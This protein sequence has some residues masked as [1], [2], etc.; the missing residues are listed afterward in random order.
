[1]RL[2]SRP[3]NLL[4]LDEPTNDLDMETLDLLQELIEGF[5]GTVI[6]VSHDRDFLDRT[7]TSTIAPEGDGRWIEYAGGFSDMMAQ[8]KGEALRR[9]EKSAGSAPRGEGAGREAAQTAAR[10][11]ARKLSYKQKYA[12][13]TLP[14]RIEELNGKIALLEE[15]LADTTLYAR[16]PDAFSRFTKELDEKRAERDRLEEEWLELEILREEIEAGQA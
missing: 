12:P 13:D 6:L 11:G 10:Q 7:V 8:R 5:P 1:A 4:V 16:D 14:R 3:A 9:R 15:K 2:L